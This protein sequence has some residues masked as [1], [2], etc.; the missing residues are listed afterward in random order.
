MTN[1]ITFP[2]PPKPD[3]RWIASAVCWTLA[4]ILAA[5]VTLA[6]GIRIGVGW[7]QRADAALGGTVDRTIAIETLELQRRQADALDRMAAAMERP[8]QVQQAKAK[9]AK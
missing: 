1:S 5:S 6:T 7:Q 3:R 4:G 2:I 9:V 8:V